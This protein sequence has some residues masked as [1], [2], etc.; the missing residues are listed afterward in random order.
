M[1]I[2]FHGEAA[3]QPLMGLIA[4]LGTSIEQLAKGN[5]GVT[6]RAWR[7]FGSRSPAAAA[8]THFDW[9]RRKGQTPTTGRRSRR[10]A[11]RSTRSSSPA[12]SSSARASC[13]TRHRC[14]SSANRSGDGDED[15]HPP[16]GHCQRPA[17]RHQ[18]SS[19]SGQQATRSR[20]SATSEEG[21]ISHAPNRYLKKLVACGGMVAEEVNNHESPTKN[22]GPAQ[23]PRQ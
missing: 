22:I 14:S 11:G 17:R 13:A 5:R 1:A 18:T 15:E 12:R 2:G 21:S 7:W 6:A 19:A 23:W 10:C 4:K 9:A 8:S 3:F 16:D 20:S